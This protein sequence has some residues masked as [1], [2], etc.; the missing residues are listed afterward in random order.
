V[1][2]QEGAN[3]VGYR[4]QEGSPVMAQVDAKTVGIG[5]KRAALSWRKRAPNRGLIS[6]KRSALGR[7]K[8]ASTVWFVGRKRAA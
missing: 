3:N 5:C 6:C 7:R 1:V 4:L 8:R 2:A